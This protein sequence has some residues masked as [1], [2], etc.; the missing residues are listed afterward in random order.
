MNS[1]KVSRWLTLAANLGVLGGL[2]L[3]AAELNQNHD[4]MRAQ[5]RHQLAVEAIGFLDDTSR[6][7]DMMRIIVAVM[8]GES[9]S[10]EDALRYRFRQ[11]AYFE[12]Q[13]NMYYQYTQG[14]FDEAEYQA[15]K[16]GMAGYVNMHPAIG[17]IYCSVREQYSAAFRREV[18]PLFTDPQC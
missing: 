11:M 7:A 4:L 3:L 17:R 14:L 16:A 5:T 10:Q 13:E 18:D 12:R 2:V 8:N 6:D 9:L 15:V 1:E